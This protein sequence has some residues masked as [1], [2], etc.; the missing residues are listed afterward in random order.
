M[1]RPRSA[2]RVAAARDVDVLRSFAVLNRTFLSFFSTA[3][4]EWK[5]S[6]SEGVMLAN[7]GHRPGTSQET[8]SVELVIDKAAVARAVKSLKRRGLLRVER[9]DED[10][11]AHCLYL[12]RQGEAVLR[13][14][15]ALNDRWLRTITAGLSPQEHRVF[16]RVLARLVTRARTLPEEL[17]PR[18][19][20]HG[21]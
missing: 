7:V 5:L 21:R 17:P 1:T 15:D 4:A 13:K 2:A 16:F 6:Y 3:L 11:R 14:I 10:R 20:P 19:R 18:R 12:T 9:S 8:L